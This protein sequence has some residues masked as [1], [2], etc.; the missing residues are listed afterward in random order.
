MPLP[1]N[2][3]NSV[4]K[5]KRKMPGG[6]S[7]TRYERRQ[8]GGKHSCATCSRRL[9]ATHSHS[10]LA[11]SSRKPNR[12][13]G[14]MLCPACARRAIILRSRLKEGAITLDA[15]EVKFLPYVKS[16]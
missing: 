16:K 10:Y 2:R 3:S 14:G 15:V 6:K 4:R 9:Q 13:F 1:K 8:K 5:I 7:A 11:P 12:K